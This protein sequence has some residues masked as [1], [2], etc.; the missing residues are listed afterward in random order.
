MQLDIITPDKTLF[1]GE[2]DFVKV[3]GVE[4]EMGFLSN[5][6]PII[7]TLAKGDVMIRNNEGDQTFA[8]NGGV[9][10]VNNNKVIVLAE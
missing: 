8:I 9:V 3:P 6:A 7:T 1:T 4:G 10:E 2:V 5:H